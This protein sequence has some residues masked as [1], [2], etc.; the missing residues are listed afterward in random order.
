MKKQISVA[1]LVSTF[2]RPKAL[3]TVLRS[4]ATQSV[5]PDEILIADDGSDLHTRAVI[6]DFRESTEI[7]VKHFWQKND[8]FQKAVILNKAVAGTRCDYI[9]QIDG[10]VV[11]HQNFIED[12]VSASEKGYFLR[13]SRVVLNEGKTNRVIDADMPVRISPFDKGI[14]NRINSLR[15]PLIAPFMDK[16]SKRSD[17]MHGCNCSYWRLDFVKVNG[18]NNVFK[19]WGH[20]DIELAARFINAGLSQKKI[21]LRAVCYH[22]Y[23]AV[24]ERS[25]VETNFR[26]YEDCVRS[27]NKFCLNGYSQHHAY[28]Y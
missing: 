5:L 25:R 4:V 16:Y 27:G 11:L 24:A 18:Y 23:H 1:L 13:G 7:V 17:N 28:N 20:E 10:D 19:G 14:Q 3:R 9:V 6:E 2:D 26:F 21:K 22:L 12:H 8:G 15:I